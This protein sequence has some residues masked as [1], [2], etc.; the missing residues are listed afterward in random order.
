MKPV[1]LVSLNVWGGICFE[2]LVS[3][4]KERA[5]ATDIFCFQEVYD[6]N[7]KLVMDEGEHTDLLDTMITLLPDHQHFFAAKV[8]GFHY[9]GKVDF[10]LMFGNVIF[11]RR[12]LKVIDYKE[13][14]K[15]EVTHGSENTFGKSKGQKLILESEGEQFLVCALHGQW[16]KG[17]AVAGS[18]KTDTPSRIE[19]ARYVHDEMFLFA[20]KKVLCGD[21]NLL[22]DTQSMAGHEQ[23]MRNLIKEA[24]VSSTRSARY[25]KDI[26]FADYMLVSTDVA[27][28][29]SEVI[30]NEVSDHLPLFLKFH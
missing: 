1:T 14:F 28:D 26:K 3:F 18:H 7:E 23:G 22:P 19:E 30:Q 16:V 5:D 25:T 27:V 21:F 24:A 13:L 11:V 8:N 20:G 4:I 10:R 12:N 9:N 29:A 17:D 6:S 2:A 15:F